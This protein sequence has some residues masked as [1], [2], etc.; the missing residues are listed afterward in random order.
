MRSISLAAA[1]VALSI[2]AP[3]GHVASA[4][5]HLES[6]NGDLSGTSASPTPFT[7][8]AGANTLSGDASPSDFDIVAITI[9]TGHQLDSFILTQY[10]NDSEF[11]SSFMGLQPGNTW[12]TGM[13]TGVAGDKLIGWEVFDASLA[14]T[15]LLPLMAANGASLNPSGG[16]SVPLPAGTYTLLLQDTATAF[17]YAFSFNVSTVPEPATL[18]IAGTAVAL[19]AL[20]RRQPRTSPKFLS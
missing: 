6:I 16:F 3:L 5:L 12:T 4:A 19:L 8:T 2:A 1:T 10:T 14:N 17:T 11:G 15:N 20:R 7:L 9:P 18:G 13:G